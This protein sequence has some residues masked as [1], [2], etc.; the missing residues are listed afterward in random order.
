MTGQNP[1][2]LND[3]GIVNEVRFCQEFVE[4]MPLICVKGKFYGLDGQISDD[5]IS[6]IESCGTIVDIIKMMTNKAAML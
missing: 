6:R 1:A 5:T 2:W 3:K 4:K